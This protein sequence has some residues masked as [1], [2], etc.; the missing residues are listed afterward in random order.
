MFRY[1]Q[2]DTGRPWECFSSSPEGMQEALS[3]NP[4]GVSI[5]E[6]S[7]PYDSEDPRWD[8]KAIKYRGPFYLDIDTPNIEDSIT[9][10]LKVVDKLKGLNVPDKAIQLY[11]SGTKG[12][13]LEVPMQ[14]FSNG[15]ATAFLPFIYRSIAESFEVTGVDLAVYK[16]KSGLIWRRPNIPRK[17][18][19]R[20]VYKV[21]LTIQELN[22]LD[23]D[24]YK[25]LVSKPRLDFQFSQLDKT[26]YSGKFE[27]FFEG[28]KAKVR[29]EQINKDKK[30]KRYSAVSGEKIK[31]LNGTAP[32]CIQH[33]LNYENLKEGT[34]FNA[35][36]MQVASWYSNADMP[37]EEVYEKLRIYAAASKS[38]K[39]YDPRSRFAHVE[40]L[41][42]RPDLTFSCGAIRTISENRPCDGCALNSFAEGAE[43]INIKSRIIEKDGMTFMESL[44]PEK[45]PI[46][47]LNCTIAVTK[48][49]NQTPLNP[50]EAET[51]VGYYL[52]L[53]GPD[54][55]CAHNVWADDDNF[56]TVGSLNSLLSRYHNFVW[57][58]HG[59]Y[60]PSSAIK[61]YLFSRDKIEN[62]V[63]EVKRVHAAGIECIQEG[64]VYVQTYVED[65][66]SLD[67]YGTKYSHE[68]VTG[69]F[70]VSGAMVNPRVFNVTFHE[71]FGKD[72]VEETILHLINCNTNEVMGK[73]L[74][75]T[76]ACF[77]KSGMRAGLATGNFPLL[78]L[79]GNAGSGK[80]SLASLL[81]RLH[82]C[83]GAVINCPSST[84]WAAA[85]TIASSNSV[86]VVMD[87][88][89][90]NKLDKAKG[91]RWIERMK[92][93]YDCS[94]AIR[95]E[96]RGNQKGAT[97]AGG[98]LTGPVILLSEQSVGT[99]ALQHRTVSCHLRARTNH[100]YEDSY[101]HVVD[102][103]EHLQWFAKKLVLKVLKQDV[104]YI[105][106]KM[107]KYKL[108]H[109]IKMGDRPRLNMAILRIGLEFLS[110]TLKDCGMYQ[111]A[112][113]LEPLY[114]KLTS[115]SKVAP[116]E[117]IEA[118]SKSAADDLLGMICQMIRT[119]LLHP[120]EGFAANRLDRGVDYK[121]DDTTLTISPIGLY[122]KLAAFNA[123]TQK[124]ALV[125][126]NPQ[127]LLEL[128]GDEEYCTVTGNENLEIDMVSAYR[129][130]VKE[131]K[132]LKTQHNIETTLEASGFSA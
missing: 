124:G 44:D 20:T 55:R 30:A 36:S 103:P 50:M 97:V 110:S 1:C 3:R 35:V 69:G 82:G 60:D 96:I 28:L 76:V 2:V 49:V 71:E 14:V 39:Y 131:V 10:A 117:L 98:K 78:S 122:F 65:R 29:R 25:V 9:S 123:H 93:T 74:G 22:A 33:F 104:S 108:E 37:Q 8:Q 121:V 4:W 27:T 89:L 58:R 52:D 57:L 38:Q 128:L 41:L 120:N 13:H 72:E 12:F 100:M 31:T 81:T 54:G 115:E 68:L 106:T 48:V 111:A 85:Q 45:G 66:F 51:R 83:E 113:A 26:D 11:A 86:P 105:H 47:M 84:D 34:N 19:E 129:K 132:L 23:A 59:S 18:G 63:N 107:R 46:P 75:W 114:E 7:E 126:N 6:M 61:E 5:L 40:N 56:T 17:A 99:P 101:H 90:S 80:T 127:Q 87:E 79:Y 62:E 94:V 67:S 95:G 109:D 43:G 64:K 118:K 53:D 102:H 119:S 16:G 32:K 70:A 21:P 24:S 130:G 91:S 125:I 116:K 112:E 73:V 42:N 92:S 88:F 77:M 15:K